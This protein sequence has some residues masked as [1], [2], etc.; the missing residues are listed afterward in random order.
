MKWGMS[1][2]MRSHYYFNSSIFRQNFR[3]HGWIGIIYALGLLFAL[4]LQLFMSSNPD[5]KPQEVDHLFRIAGSVQALF[6]ITIPVAAGLF[7]FRYLQAKSPAD[8]WHSLPL[9]REHIFTA[10]LTSGLTLLL[11]PVWLTAGV[12]A[13]VKPWSGNFYIFQGADIWQWC[14]TVSI[15][16]L[17]LFCFS[18]FVGICTA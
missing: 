12:V 5:A 3:Q 4:P 16:T 7:L 2:M 13:V 17:F 1:D 14:I 9:R 18:V 6:I 10:H 8:L 11:L 15:L